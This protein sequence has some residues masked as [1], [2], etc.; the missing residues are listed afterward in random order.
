MIAGISRQ[1]D[2]QFCVSYWE[3]VS[4]FNLTSPKSL[5]QSGTYFQERESLQTGL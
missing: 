2:C 3:V 5:K 4:P 1:T